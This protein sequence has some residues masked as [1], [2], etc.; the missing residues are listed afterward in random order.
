MEGKP[1]LAVIVAYV[2]Y[3]AINKWVWTPMKRGPKAIR[4]EDDDSPTVPS[5]LAESSSLL[6][7]PS[8]ERKDDPASL[9][10][11]SAEVSISEVNQKS[12]DLDPSVSLLSSAESPSAPMLKNS[13]PISEVNQESVD[14]D[15]STSLLSLAESSLSASMRDNPEPISDVNQELVDIDLSASLLSSAESSSAPMLDNREPILEVNQELE[16]LDPSTSLLSLAES[17]SSASMLEIPEPISEVN[18]ES[19]DVAPFAS[20][21]SSAESSSSAS[22]LENPEPILEVNQESVDLR[23]STSL[24]SAPL[25]RYDVFLNF[26]GEDTRKNFVPHLYNELKEV[27]GIETFKD[28]R[29]LEI[30]DRIFATLQKAI[31][32]SKCAI[33]VLSKRYAESRW[34]LKELVKICQCMKDNNRILPIFYHVEPCEVRFQKGCF[35][36]AFTKHQNSGRQSSEEVEEW[37][38]ALRTVA[39]FSGCNTKDHGDEREVIDHIVESVCSKIQ[40]IESD[41]IFP[42]GNFVSFEATREAMNNVMKALDGNTAVGIYG[43]GGVGKTTMVEHVAREVLKNGLFH[44]VTMAVISQKPNYWKIQERLASMLKV[45]LQSTDEFARAA[46][47]QSKIWGREKILIILDDIWAEIQL[48]HIGIPSLEELKRRNS[49]VLLTTRNEDVCSDMCCQEKIHLNTLSEKDSWMLFEKN[50]GMSFQEKTQFCCV[51]KEVAR[52]CAGLPIALEAVAKALKNKDLK[53]WRAAVGRLKLSRTPHPESNRV[54]FNSINLSYEYLKSNDSRSC[55]LLCCLFPEDYDIQIEDLLKYGIGK[56]LFQEESDMQQARDA[57]CLVV[58]SLK[59]YSLLLDGKMGGGCVR[60]HDVIRDVGL[61]ISLSKDGYRDFFVRAGWKLEDWPLNDAPEYYT[62]ISLMRNKIPELPEELGFPELQILLLQSNSLNG[63]PVSSFQRLKVLRV[64]DISQTNISLLPSSSNLLTSLHTLYL[65]GCLSMES[66]IPLLGQLK[67][68]KILSMREFPHQKLPKEIGQLT[69]LKLLDFTS[70]SVEI[71]PPKVIGNLSKLEELYMK[72]YFADWGS[73]VEGSK[74]KGSEVEGNIDEENKAMGVGEETNAFFDELTNLSGLHILNV[75]ISD[76]NCMPITVRCNPKWISFDICI[77]SD[78]SVI[79][80][81][82]DS[83]SSPDYPKALTLGITMDTLRKWEWF[84]DV[85]TKK[86]EKLQYKNCRDLG[87][88]LMEYEWGRLHELKYLSVIGPNEKLKELINT[89]TWVQ[90]EPVFQNLEELHL[91]QVDSLKELCVGELPLGSLC[92]LRLLKVKHCYELVDALL[93]SQL[94]QR[95]QNLEKLI[96]EEM[97][98]LEYVFG[99][100]GLKPEHIIMT[101]LKEMRL[102]NLGKLIKIWNGPAPCAIFQNLQSLVVS[103]CFD[104]ENLFTADVAQCLL[105]LQDLSVELCPLLDRVIEES[106]ETIDSKIVFPK[107]KSLALIQLPQLTR[108]YGNTGSAIECPLLEYL[109]VE[110][111]PQFSIPDFHSRN[112]V[113]FNRQQ[114]FDI[115]ERRLLRNK[116]RP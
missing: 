99:C 25:Q 68:L 76:A 92:N 24:F 70:Q 7:P 63:I 50:T 37:R 113:Q 104:L 86:T 80:W 83:S 77:S 17:S 56:G 30:G 64:L 35:A 53:Q 44:Q 48:K 106:K 19:V 60:M 108:L 102:E 66:N 97:D 3:M 88:I 21:L 57:I 91:I 58:Q 101:E 107:M 69:K 38:K 46:T 23:P 103:G 2:S 6:S 39:D 18:Q 89:K 51:A 8:P 10:S 52:E 32:E 49:T 20:L 5:S 65:D 73:S 110:R 61:S 87:N 96:C 11:S 114:H 71:V 98:E 111:C 27:R 47:L 54:V 84:I 81:H 75:V 13:E 55:F 62:A 90:N 33:V 1:I 26:R 93:S 67:Q 14:L 36:E 43:M 40:T 100:E 9:P 28:D 78:Q 45:K 31:E 4:K 34:C 22:V 112:R 74:V 94:L 42:L 85:V 95:L 105:Q 109:Y 116:R 82:L 79:K 59:D 12:V 72:C 41:R 16:D 15:P 115:I 29:E